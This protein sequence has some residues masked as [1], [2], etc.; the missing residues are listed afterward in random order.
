MGFLDRRK[1]D[2]EKRKRVSA[3]KKEALRRD[4]E[5][6][7]FKGQRD[8]ARARGYAAGRTTLGDRLVKTISTPP[9]K[10]SAPRRRK[11]PR[12]RSNNNMFGDWPIV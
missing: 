8:R 12:R 10:R 3:I 4:F 11:T 7:K 5:R 1:E 9:P 6:A 2:K